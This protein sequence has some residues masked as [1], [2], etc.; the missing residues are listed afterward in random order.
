MSPKPKD[1]FEDS[2]MGFGEH[3]EELRVHVVKALL[4][5]VVAVAITLTFGNYIVAIVRA[6]IDS[7]LLKFGY[8]E[9][10]Q[11]DLGSK[12]FFDY[13][14]DWT[15][16]KKETPKDGEDPAPPEKKENKSNRWDGTEITVKVDAGELAVALHEVAPK[17]YP[18]PTSE[19]TD[20]KISLILDAPEF[21]LIREVAKK[22]SK[23]VT[24]NVQEAFLTFLKVAVVAG[25]LLASPWI[26]Y[27]I[28]QFVA[29]GLYPHERSYVYIYGTM[30]LVLFLGG[31]LFCF[32]FVFPFVLDFLLGFNKWLEV[33]PQIRL[34]EWIT[35]AIMLPLMFG[36]SFQLPLV[37]MFLERLS[38]FEVK[39]YKE[40]WRMAILVICIISMLMTPA[41]PTSMLMMAIPL[42]GLYF[43]GI[44]L[45]YFSRSQNPFE[46]EIATT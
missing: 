16:P 37:M 4:G 32:F 36:V 21:G 26:F 11:D 13:I 10:V 46:D 20:K 45:C 17:S 7:A 28:W 19:L 42:V 3:L 25:L 31:S 35:F 41:D 29:V 34:S 14:Q 22:T 6:P 40:Q 27:Q 43:M 18:K 15:S 33:T 8:S 38:I 5:L 24:L 23:P 2:T 9:Y 39:D 30:S 44:Y 1:L 12:G